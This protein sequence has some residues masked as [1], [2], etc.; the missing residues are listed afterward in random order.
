MNFPLI[1]TFSS[2][3]LTQIT[4]KSGTKEEEDIVNYVSSNLK[5]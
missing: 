4:K 5:I 2:N 1:S 3:F